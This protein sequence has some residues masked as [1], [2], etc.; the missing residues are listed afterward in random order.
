M[1]TLTKL[2]SFLQDLLAVDAIKDYCP[3]GI[4]VAG[5][6]QLRKIVTGVTACQRLLSA[7]LAAKADAVLVHHGY[8]WKNE[9]PCVVGIKQ[10]RLKL[11][12]E[13]NMSLLAYHLPLDVHPQ[14]G[15]NVQLAKLLK[16][17][18]IKRFAPTKDLELVCQGQLAAPQSVEQFAAVLTQKLQ[19]S[20]LFIKGSEKKIKTLA[21][22]TGA[23]Q[24]FIEFAADLA[25]DAYVTGEVSERT[26]HIAREREI[27]FF[28][29]GHHATERYGIAA[30]GEYVAKRFEVQHQFIDIDNPV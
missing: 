6:E 14:L 5:R 1:V 9:D 27:H 8:F 11:L 28:A 30:L 22:C 23:G 19:R 3:N 24:D 29:A 12:L 17:K 26:V 4:Q 18:N 21:W 16:I 13:N 2:A 7:A 25:V 10:Q 20:P 15:N